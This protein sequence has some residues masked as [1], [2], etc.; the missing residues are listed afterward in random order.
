DRQLEFGR[1][2]E[3][4]MR[5]SRAGEIAVS[6]WQEIP[7]HHV[8]VELDAFVV[9]PNHVHGLIALTG[10]GLQPDD[11]PPTEDAKTHE[12]ARRDRI[13]P[14]PDT[15]YGVPTQRSHQ[16]EGVSLSTVVGTYKAAVTRTVNR[17]LGTTGSLWQPRFHDRIVR[18]RDPDELAALRRYIA[19]NPVRW[20]QDRER[21][22]S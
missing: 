17:Q 2:V 7:D 1:I 4:Q 16:R 20:P 18:L 21:P 13:Y 22:S 3:G 14:V 9:M 6:C 5:L 8:G 19:E 11:T 12:D 10:A 15:M